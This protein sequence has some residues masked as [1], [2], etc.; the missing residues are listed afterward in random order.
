MRCASVWRRVPA[1]KKHRSK[2]ETLMMFSA[3]MM[4]EMDVSS[5]DSK[6]VHL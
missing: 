1:S 5:P 6:V 2:A 4:L 3:R